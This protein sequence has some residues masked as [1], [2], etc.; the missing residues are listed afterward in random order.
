MSKKK[1]SIIEFVGF[2]EDQEE[3]I[4]EHLAEEFSDLKPREDRQY[5]YTELKNELTEDDRQQLLEILGHRCRQSTKKKLQNRL[6]RFSGSVPVYGV[7]DRLLYERGQWQYCA[8]QSYTDEI[9]TVRKIF[10]E[11][12]E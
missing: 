8:G 11:E 1:N 10:L 6:E 2:T 5:T 9:R 12:Y 7:I 4:W 3:K